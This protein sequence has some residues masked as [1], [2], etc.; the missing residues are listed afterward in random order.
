M[1]LELSR[2]NTSLVVVQINGD[3][4]IAA[5]INDVAQPAAVCFEQTNHSIL[6]GGA[7]ETL[8]L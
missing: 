2:R 7:D 8:D 6:A 3:R 1:K 5:D 4:I